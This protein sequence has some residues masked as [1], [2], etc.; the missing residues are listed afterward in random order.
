MVLTTG[1]Y[2][3]NYPI[4]TV[5]CC[6]Y[7][8]LM[9]QSKHNS[10]KPL[11]SN[12]KCYDPRSNLW[13]VYA[14]PFLHAHISQNKA[15][16]LTMAIKCNIPAVFSCVPKTT[17][18]YPISCTKI[19]LFLARTIIIAF[20]IYCHNFKIL[21]WLQDGLIT[22]CTPSDITLINLTQIYILSVQT[23]VNYSWSL[24]AHHST[25]IIHHLY[26]T[27]TEVTVRYSAWQRTKHAPCLGACS[28]IIV[29]VSTKY[30]YNRN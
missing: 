19:W 30:F 9:Q 8:I 27:Q 4:L 25:T 18:F 26:N 1:Y 12:N 15:A 14:Q 29:H 17:M 3:Q 11:H 21:S 10:L 6:R 20:S 23:T 13:S 22:T 24:I 7:I 2:F 5:I 16:V 28:V